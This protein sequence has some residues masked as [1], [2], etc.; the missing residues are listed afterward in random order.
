MESRQEALQELWEQDLN[1]K[2]LMNCGKT[3][4][5]FSTENKVI[6][7]SYPQT[8]THCKI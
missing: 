5:K 8:L 1:S 2:C 7:S 6:I 4:I 3:K